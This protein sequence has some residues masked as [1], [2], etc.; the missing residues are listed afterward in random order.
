MQYSSRKASRHLAAVFSSVLM[1]HL[2]HSGPRDIRTYIVHRVPPE[3][4]VL[5]RLGAQTSRWC[6]SHPDLGFLRL[7]PPRHNVNVISSATSKHS[8]SAR[9]VILNSSKSHSLLGHHQTP[10]FGSSRT[11]ASWLPH[12]L[13]KPTSTRHGSP[14]F[15]PLNQWP[16]NQ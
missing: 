15:K 16:H 10:H 5:L 4:L 7:A 6:S 11:V 13:P 9:A 3:V 1:L 12:T 8:T 2:P 14:R